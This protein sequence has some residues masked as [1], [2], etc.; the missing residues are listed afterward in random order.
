MLYLD[1]SE[2]YKARR[3]RDDAHEGHMIDAA[4]RDILA[5]KFDTDAVYFA[6]Q[7]GHH[8][9]FPKFREQYDIAQLAAHAAGTT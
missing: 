6:M 9:D 2:A 7:L 8:D 1:E 4:M 5:G 3:D